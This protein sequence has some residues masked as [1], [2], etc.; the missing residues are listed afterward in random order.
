MLLHEVGKPLKG[1]ENRRREVRHD[2]VAGC[3]EVFIDFAQAFHE[4]GLFLIDFGFVE[5]PRPQNFMT[6]L[7]LF[8]EF[9]RLLKDFRRIEVEAHHFAHGSF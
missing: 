1:S 8:F 6:L 7:L 5:A 9:F 3:A 4:L 2:D